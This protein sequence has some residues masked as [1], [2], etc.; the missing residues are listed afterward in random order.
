[1]NNVQPRLYVKEGCP[2]CHEASEFLDRH[3]IAYERIV[4]TGDH[5]AM[6][7]MVKVSGQSKAPTLRWNG[8]VLADFGVEELESF[9]KK[10]GAL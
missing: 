3:K 5:T 2:W 10:E 4:V 8:K 6:N 1:M 9:L 7:E